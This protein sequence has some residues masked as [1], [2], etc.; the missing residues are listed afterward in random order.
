MVRPTNTLIETTGPEA[1]PFGI[2]SPATTVVERHDDYWLSGFVYEIGD[3]RVQVDNAVILGADTPA[4]VTSVVPNTGDTYGLYFPFDIE[5]EVEHSTFGVTP[6]EIEASAQKALDVV[7]QK[8]IEVEFW[9]GGV[10]S[11]LTKENNNRYLASTQAIDVTPVPGTA[12]KP[13]YGQALLEGALGDA[14]L[15]S[16]GTIHAPRA[17]ASILKLEEDNATL[18]T[19]LGNTVVAGTGYSKLGPTG[20]AAP[21]GKYWMY[22]TGP[23]TVILGDMNIT[24][25]EKSQAINTRVNTIKYYVDRPAAVTWSTSNVYAVLI[26]LTLDYA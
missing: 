24:P 19:K 13:R 18:F 8:A 10:A 26:D 21:A 4:E 23:V 3:A 14:T 25:D 20:V 6:E 2:L 15:G 7:T 12:V 5:A 1:S 9:G 11:L 17:A 22:A 16:R